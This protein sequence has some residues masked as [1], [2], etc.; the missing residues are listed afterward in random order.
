M[1]TPRHVPVFFL[2]AV[3]VLLL[4]WCLGGSAIAAPAPQSFASP[5]DAVAAL[6]A[7][8]GSADPARMVQVLGPAAEPLVSSGDRNADIAAGKR[9]LESYAAQHALVPD[10]PGRMTLQVGT[11]DWPLP[12]PLVQA[13]GRWHFDSEAGA[14][15][16]ID[17]R[18]GSN[19]IAAIR[20]SLAY[21]DAQAD[22]FARAKAAGGPGEYAQRLVSTEGAQDGLYWPQAEGEAESP[23]GPL[24]QQAMDEGYPGELVSGRQMPYQGYFFRILRR[25]GPEAEGGARNY[26]LDGHMTGGFALLAWPASWGVSG[27]MTFLVNQDGVVFQKDLG[28]HT[29]AHAAAIASFDP[30]LSWARVDVVDT[31]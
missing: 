6:I 18:I 16:I 21:V 3:A 15:E 28:P 9:F 12:L 30:D 17:R 5:D 31:P 13:D 7:A 1:E 10:G 23:F 29:A 14:Q 24:V 2:N 25:Q 20:V 22:Y 8:V 27:V 11:N 19:E 26:V 4:A